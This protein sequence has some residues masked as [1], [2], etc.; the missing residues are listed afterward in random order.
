MLRDHCAR[1][2]GVV[3]SWPGRNP[4]CHNSISSWLFRISALYHSVEQ[5]IDAFTHVLGASLLNFGYIIWSSGWHDRQRL[6]Q[7][8]ELGPFSSAASSGSAMDVRKTLAT[9]PV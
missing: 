2:H 9:V 4:K 8:H 6:A 1:M 3:I 7:P 5:V